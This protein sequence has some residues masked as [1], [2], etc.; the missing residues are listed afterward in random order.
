[1]GQCR[2]EWYLRNKVELQNKLDEKTRHWNKKLQPKDSKP[3][4]FDKPLKYHTRKKNIS[5]L[6][7]NETGRRSIAQYEKK[8]MEEFQNRE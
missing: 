4:N 5:N 1:M 2:K 6:Q 8:H 7:I 3:Q